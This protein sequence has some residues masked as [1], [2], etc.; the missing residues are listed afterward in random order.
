MPAH[1]KAGERWKNEDEPHGSVVQD[2]V[3][4]VRHT[5]RRD[6]KR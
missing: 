5:A 4:L 1:P 6:G 3:R 2:A